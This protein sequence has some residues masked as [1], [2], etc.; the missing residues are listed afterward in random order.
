MIH[1]GIEDIIC[2][3]KVLAIGFASERDGDIYTLP[4][5]SG[6]WAK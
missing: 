4:R 6:L 3:F 2:L 5:D 1:T